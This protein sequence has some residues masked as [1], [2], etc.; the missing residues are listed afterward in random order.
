MAV[1]RRGGFNLSE[2]VD[3]TKPAAHNPAA[4]TS[5]AIP[6]GSRTRSGKKSST[7]A[8]R[9]ASHHLAIGAAVPFEGR[10]KMGRRLSGW[11]SPG[12][13]G[14]F[15]TVPSLAR[16][17][18]ASECSATPTRDR[19]RSQRRKKRFPVRHSRANRNRGPNSPLSTQ[20]NPCGSSPERHSPGSS[21]P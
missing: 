8:S 13:P 3:S 14:G 9:P 19:F 7:A 6:R 16:S 5:A 11:C 12:I 4:E 18:T 17:P 2:R 20:Q 1:T 15:R 21:P 10:R